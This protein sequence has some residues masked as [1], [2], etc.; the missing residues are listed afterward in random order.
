MAYVLNLSV[1]WYNLP[2][3][4]YTL[5]EIEQHVRVKQKIGHNTK[6]LQTKIIIV[7]T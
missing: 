3:S 1:L 6:L 5:H 2:L 4:N 7:D